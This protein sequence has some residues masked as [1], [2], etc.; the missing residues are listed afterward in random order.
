M[1]EKL[2]FAVTLISFSVGHLVPLGMQVMGAVLG[3]MLL[4]RAI[5][6]IPMERHV[7][8]ILDCFVTGFLTIVLLGNLLDTPHPTAHLVFFALLVVAYIN[9]KET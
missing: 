3:L 4:G 2:L 8:V 1:W 6:W 5:S 9:L 7:S